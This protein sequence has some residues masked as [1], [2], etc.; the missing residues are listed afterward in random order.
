MASRSDGSVPAGAAARLRPAPVPVPAPVPEE[1]HHGGT[2]T[3]TE[4]NTE[5]PSC[6]AA[7]RRAASRSGRGRCQG[8]GFRVQGSGSRG[9]A[10]QPRRGDGIKPRVS[11][12]SGAQNDPKGATESPGHERVR[13]VKILCGG[14]GAVRTQRAA[15]PRVSAQKSDGGPPLFSRGSQSRACPPARRGWC[16]SRR[17]GVS[18]ARQ[19]GGPRSCFAAAPFVPPARLCEPRL[20]NVGPPPRLRTPPLN[21][22]P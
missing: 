2:R 15:L 9:S 8:S 1:T 19:A 7:A 20:N 21:P 10:T 12:D 11:E 5:G 3:D 6:L 22:E 17:A 4:A 18:V 14:G 16:A 13:D